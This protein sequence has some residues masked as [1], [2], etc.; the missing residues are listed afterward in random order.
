MKLKKQKNKT[1]TY[2]HINEKHTPQDDV[3]S[4][5]IQEKKGIH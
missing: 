3:D 4:E 1:R 2:L 5:H